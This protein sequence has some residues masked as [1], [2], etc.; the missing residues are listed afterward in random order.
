MALWRKIGGA[1][2][3]VASHNSELWYSGIMMRLL[4]VYDTP[5]T[6]EWALEKE[7]KDGSKAGQEDDPIVLEIENG[8]S[9]VLV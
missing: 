6:L 7:A 2:Y 4:W 8:Q 9:L 3:W 1:K 5:R